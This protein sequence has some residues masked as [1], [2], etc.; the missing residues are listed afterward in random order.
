MGKLLR[1]KSRAWGAGPWLSDWVRT[2]HFG[3]PGFHWFG[4]W[5][6]TRYCSSG[7]SEVASQ[8]PQPEGPTTRIHNYVPGGFGEKKGKKKIGNRY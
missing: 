8:M 6:W 7:H 4:S 5:V 3:G 2:L 1:V